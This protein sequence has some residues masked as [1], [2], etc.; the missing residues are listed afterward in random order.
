[1]IIPLFN[2]VWNFFVL[3]R[4]PESYASYFHSI[5]RTDVGDAG[6]SLGLWAA[7][8]AAVGILPIPCIGGLAGLAALV[9]VIILLVKLYGLKGQIGVAGYPGQGFPPVQPPPP[10]PAG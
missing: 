8:C 10:P 2:V 3:Q 5:G 9:L 6:K 7:I 4:V 1:M